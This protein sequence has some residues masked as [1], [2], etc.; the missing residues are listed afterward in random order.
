M[1]GKSVLVVGGTSGLGLEI[2]KLLWTEGA[3]V[4][5]SG[6]SNEKDLGFPHYY[7]TLDLSRWV[8]NG[9]PPFVD[10]QV[11]LIVHAAGFFQEGRIDELTS[12]QIVEMNNVGLVAPEIMIGQL[13]ADQGRLDGFIAIT[14]TSQW[15][16]R[17]KEPVYNGVKSGLAMFAKAVSL[18]ERVGKVLV[19]A[20]AGMKTAFWRGGFAPE[21]E[22]LDPAWVAEQV[23][24]EYELTKKYR[25]TK[26]LREPPDVQLVEWRDE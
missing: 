1:K 5:L 13:L 18:D 22:L 16:P 4:S 7:H 17:L 10:Y 20:P 15:T 11:D 12:T 6:R 21:G 26:I 24:L 9:A 19:A 25:F 14:S 23:L 8:E 3:T 2:A